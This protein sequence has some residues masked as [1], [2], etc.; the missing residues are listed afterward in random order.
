LRLHVLDGTL[1]PEDIFE[2]LWK[3]IGSVPML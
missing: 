2:K 3:I 1:P